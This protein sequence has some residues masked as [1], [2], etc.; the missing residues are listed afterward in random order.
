MT[1]TYELCYDPR[2]ANMLVYRSVR[3]GV[4]GPFS[5]SVPC[6]SR[7]QAAELAFGMGYHIAGSWQSHTNY[8]S[9]PLVR[10]S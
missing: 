1:A 7:E 9:A 10:M 5:E 4:C 6:E 2:D 3:A 8:D